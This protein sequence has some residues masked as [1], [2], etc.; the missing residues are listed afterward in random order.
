MINNN[1]PNTGKLA[2][3][4]RCLPGSEA[5][6]QEMARLAEFQRAKKAKEA[7]EAVGKPERDA[8]RKRVYEGSVE[9]NKLRMSKR[10][11]A[12]ISYGG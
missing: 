6:H 1:T 7:E 2:F 12:R 8:E 9:A 11:P 4:T 3:S 10:Q 5:E